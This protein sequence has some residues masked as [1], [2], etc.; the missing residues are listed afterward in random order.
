MKK[1][2]ILTAFKTIEEEN[3]FFNPCFE[4]LN[5]GLS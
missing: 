1:I 3:Y 4:I 5:L 2:E